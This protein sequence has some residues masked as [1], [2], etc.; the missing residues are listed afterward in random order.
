MF[1]EKTIRAI[2]L[3]TDGK[4]VVNNF[5]YSYENMKEIVGGWLEA[6][7]LRHDGDRTITI[8]LNEEGKL[9]GLK[10]NLAVVKDG[11]LIDVIVG[12]I[13]ITATNA[14]GETV[15]LNDEELDY[16]K[17]VINLNQSVIIGDMFIPHVIRLI[18]N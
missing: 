18:N 1:M 10:P 15:G 16:V 13:L 9:I 4:F 11:E 12:D 8:W 17:N 2:L 5:K 6:F 7:T 14:E 3:K